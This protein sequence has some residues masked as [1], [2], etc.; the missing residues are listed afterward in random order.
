M[1]PEPDCMRRGLRQCSHR[2]QTSPTS[3]HAMK[4]AASAPAAALAPLVRA[5]S[6]GLFLPAV[7]DLERVQPAPLPA[8]NLLTSICDVS[9]VA[10]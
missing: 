10:W 1:C 8:H 6:S 7:E 4:R 2:A 9:P 3:L 5:R